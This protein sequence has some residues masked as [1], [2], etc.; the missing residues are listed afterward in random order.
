MTQSLQSSPL[1]IM[2]T[3]AATLNVAGVY[4]WQPWKKGPAAFPQAP[5][6]LGWFEIVKNG[7]LV[8][9]GPRKPFD[10]WAALG[11]APKT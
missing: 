2:V 11:I 5:N 6:G 4:Q 9:D 7:Q 10:L 3:A 1:A 8:L